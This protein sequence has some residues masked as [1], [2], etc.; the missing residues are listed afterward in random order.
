VFFNQP[1]EQDF[2][3]ANINRVMTQLRPGDVITDLDCPGCRQK[4]VLVLARAGDD[5]FDF[6]MR[7]PHISIIRDTSGP[8]RWTSHRQRFVSK[9]GKVYDHIAADATVLEGAGM[10]ELTWYR[11]LQN[12]PNPRFPIRLNDL[13]DSVASEPGLRLKIEAL[14]N[15]EPKDEARNMMRM[16]DLIFA[17]A[18]TAVTEKRMRLLMLTM[19][20]FERRGT[21]IGG[22]STGLGDG[23][24]VLLAKQLSGG[25]L[26]GGLE[27]IFG[28]PDGLKSFFGDPDDDRPARR[29][30]HAH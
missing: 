9:A 5:Y 2:T 15:R 3:M 8:W 19:K 21:L 26:P 23:P 29:P 17:G 10:L 28:G 18:E 12:A 24:G 14:L 22:L 11:E 7:A 25:K 30:A 4:Q 13:F 27:A 1:T 16:I 20:S 6:S